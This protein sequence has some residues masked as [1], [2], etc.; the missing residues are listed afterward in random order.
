MWT[1]AMA[2]V[3][4]DKLCFIHFISPSSFGSFICKK[5]D[6]SLLCHDNSKTLE[7]P[8]FHVNIGIDKTMEPLV[9][10]PSNFILDA[11]SGHP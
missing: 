4:F 3:F 11:V 6:Y 5:I 8:S 1:R 10:L 7:D 9:F 2:N